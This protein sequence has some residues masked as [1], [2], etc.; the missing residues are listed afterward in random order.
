MRM[1]RPEE[2][3]RHL[4]ALELSNTPQDPHAASR[5]FSFVENQLIMRFL[6]SYLDCSNEMVVSCVESKLFACLRGMRSYFWDKDLTLLASTQELL[7]WWER[8]F[9]FLWWKKDTKSKLEWHIDEVAR[10]TGTP[11][12]PVSRKP[13]GIIEADKLWKEKAEF[14]KVVRELRKKQEEAWKK[15]EDS[16]KEKETKEEK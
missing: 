14:E 9:G 6:I 15:L 11:V 12:N 2:V 13:L 16:G 4:Q 8:N 10:Y 7:C 3:L 5:L 1:E